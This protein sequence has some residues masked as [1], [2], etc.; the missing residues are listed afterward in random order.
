MHS[1]EDIV[2]THKI[3]LVKSFNLW[4]LAF[5]DFVMRV[6]KFLTCRIGKQCQCLHI[7][8]DSLM[9]LLLIFFYFL[10]FRLCCYYMRGRLPCLAL[11]LRS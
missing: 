6:R 4:G 1:I 10:C 11:F 7:E 2:N 5:A 8:I 3:K 9:Y